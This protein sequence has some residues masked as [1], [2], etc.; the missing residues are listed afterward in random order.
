[1]IFFALFQIIIIYKNQ[2]SFDDGIVT[3]KWDGLVKSLI[4]T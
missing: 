3:S 1:M 4:V 2:I